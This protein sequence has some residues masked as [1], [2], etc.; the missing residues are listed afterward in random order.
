M[1][2]I[3][4]Q[5]EDWIIAV[6]N[7]S[8]ANVNEGIADPTIQHSYRHLILFNTPKIFRHIRIESARSG[9]SAL[10]VCEIK[11]SVPGKLLEWHL[12]RCLDWELKCLVLI[13]TTE[14]FTTKHRNRSLDLSLISRHF[15]IIRSFSAELDS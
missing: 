13:L 15:D 4:I 10:T 14:L 3:T 11:M 6:G 7:N 8:M 5:F 1:K 2:G 9:N 12:L